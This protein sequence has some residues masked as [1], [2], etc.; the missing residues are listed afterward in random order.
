MLRQIERLTRVVADP[1]HG[2]H[3]IAVYAQPAGESLVPHAAAEPGFEGVACVDDAARAVV[4]YCSL[5]RAWRMDSARAAAY[6]LLRFLAL[7]QDADGRFCN[8]IVDW[9]GR[10]N[11][12]GPTSYPGGAPWQARAVHALACAIDVFGPAEWEERFALAQRWID[13]PTPFLDVRAVHVLA[14]LDHWRTTGSA[15]SAERAIAWSDEIAAHVDAGRLLN[16]ASETRSIHLWGH[17]QERALAETGCAFDRADLVACAGASAEA[18]LLPAVDGAFAF[19][20]ALPFDVSSTVAGLSAV[21]RATGDERYAA[22]AV[23]ARLWFLGRNVARQAVYDARGGRVFDGIDRGQVSRNSGA[24]SN[25]EGALA[26][27]SSGT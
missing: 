18:L 15:A 4:L 6:R 25:I 16:A 10:R 23:Q 13:Q 19:T 24:E 21:A 2:A 1:V 11:D 22:A 14:M 26:L 9:S 3:A 27:L 5:W 7:M 8:F 12:S 17:L 20:P